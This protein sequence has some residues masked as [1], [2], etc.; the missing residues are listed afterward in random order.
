MR[1]SREWRIHVQH[2]LMFTQ[3]PVLFVGYE[4]L[5]KDT[6]IEL[7]RILDFIGYP[8]SEEDVLC[9]I[10]KYGEVDSVY[11]EQL[12]SYSPDLQEF[13][14]DQIKDVDASLLKHDISILHSYH[15]N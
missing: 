2:W 15:R 12:N 5:V 1:E 6:Y 13:V 3:L 4:N 10:N 9:T 11:T 14:I 8:Y 7:K